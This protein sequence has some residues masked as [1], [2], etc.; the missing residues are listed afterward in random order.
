V[1]L[2]LHIGTEKTGTK[3]V[4]KFM[5]MNRERLRDIGVLYPLTPGNSNHMAI[6]AVAQIETK[7][8]ELPRKFDIETEERHKAFR[9]ELK[10]KLTRELA[11]SKCSKVII[12]SEHCSSRL[13][14]DVDVSYLHDFL[15]PLFETVHILVYLRRQDD[16]LLSTYSTEVKSGRT[17]RLGIPNARAIKDRYDYWELLS[18]WVRIFGREQLI[19]R[20]Y[21][22]DFLAG[23]SIIDDLLQIIGLDAGAPFERPKKLNESLD[24]DCLEFLR[25][26]NLTEQTR[27]PKIIRLLERM[28]TGP[29]LGISDRQL[30]EFM[31]RMQD[32]NLRVAREFFSGA[33]AAGGDPLFGPPT[34]FRK[35]VTKQGIAPERAVEIAANLITAIK[36]GKRRQTSTI[37]SDAEIRADQRMAS[38]PR[39]DA[40]D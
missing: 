3:S 6:A 32:S 28:S 1:E 16:F 12:S 14:S 30:T 7:V 9:D 25:L 15:S 33:V 27:W 2:Y 10:R 34:D 4:Q 31:G 17:Y 35:R 39:I 22:I 13:R 5:E 20:K 37:Q 11:E 23:G 21:S 29:L 19:C 24:A 40:L 36:E 8:G 38:R 18:R 26:M